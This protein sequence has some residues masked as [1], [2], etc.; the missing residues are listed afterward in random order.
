MV[1]EP[2]TG[3]E[4]VAAKPLSEVPSVDASARVAGCRLGAFT[5]IMARCDVEDS[6]LGDYSYICADGEVMSTDIGAFCSIAARV[7]INPGNHPLDHAALHHFTYR[8]A[9]FG[10]GTD[11]EAFFAARRRRRVV[12]GHDVW[13]GHGVTILPGVAI[14]T[15]AAIGAGA[16]VSRNVPAF[17][18]A[19]GVP[20]RPLRPRFPQAVQAGLLRIAWWRWPRERLAAAL[21][22]FRRLDA[23]AFVA[24]YDPAAGPG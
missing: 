5:E 9:Q 8:S 11:D 6:T 16:V 20:A 17:T 23:A 4:D 14:G 10:L 15:G 21:D 3:P 24:K 1:T 19:A 2:E 18:V 7:R 12:I 13:I 22:D